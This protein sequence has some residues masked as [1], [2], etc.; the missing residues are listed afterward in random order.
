MNE[1]SVGCALRRQSAHTRF[2]DGTPVRQLTD[3]VD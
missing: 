3:A 1:G 2:E